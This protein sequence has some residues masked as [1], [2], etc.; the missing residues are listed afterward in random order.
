MNRVATIP[1]VLPTRT[2]RSISHR[3]LF[4]AERYRPQFTPSSR[5]SSGPLGSAASCGG[6]RECGTG[7]GKGSADRGVRFPAMFSS[8]CKGLRGRE[9]SRQGDEV[10][11]ARRGPPTG[12]HRPPGLCLPTCWYYRSCSMIESSVA[13]MQQHCHGG[14]LAARNYRVVFATVIGGV[15][16]QRCNGCCASALFLGRSGRRPGKAEQNVNDSSRKAEG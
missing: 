2:I 7:S 12:A 14:H 9:P 1:A 15:W 13:E 16:Y 6:T 5:G 8:F 3:Y 4:R 10:Y 11:V